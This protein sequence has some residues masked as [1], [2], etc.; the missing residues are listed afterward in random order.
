MEKYEFYIPWAGE[1]YETH[2]LRIEMFTMLF[3][4]SHTTYMGKKEILHLFF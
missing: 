3:E 1:K 4:A 2:S